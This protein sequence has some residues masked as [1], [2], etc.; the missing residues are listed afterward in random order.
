MVEK[1]E[2]TFLGETYLIDSDVA[3]EIFQCVAQLPIVD[4]HTHISVEEMTLNKG[5]NN[6][7]DVFGATDH[8]VWELMRR[9]GVPEEKITGSASPKEKWISFAEIVPSIC[10]NP[11]YEWLHLELR[12][13]FGIYELVSAKTAEFIWDKLEELLKSP[14]MRPQ[15]MLRKM[16]VEVLC[17][18]ESPVCNLRWYEKIRDTVAFS[19]IIP[20]WRPDEFMEIGTAE[21]KTAIRKLE[22]YVDKELINCSELVLALERT[23][24]D[25]R[26]MG[27]ISSD[28]GI[29]DAYGKPPAMNNANKIFQKANAGKKLSS[30]EK[31]AFK[32]FLLHCFAEMDVAAGW[33]MQ[34]HLGAV[35]NYRMA[36]ARS[37]GKDAGGD[38][39]NHM[40]EIVK[41][42]YNFLNNFDEKLLII[43]Y[44][45]HPCHVYTIATLART[46]PNVIIGAPWWFMNNPYNIKEQLLQISNV[47]ILTNYIG[48]VSDARRLLSISSRFEIFRRILS[49]VL[50]DMVCKG[51]LPIE[52]AKYVCQQV[53]YYNSKKLFSK[54]TEKVNN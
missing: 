32:A 22:E 41:S 43:I 53:A 48:M 49:N 36:L 7:W 40:I 14:D 15:E 13:H 29:E 24:S 38:V 21:W 1:K 16:Q 45:L 12:R 6:A 39:A 4:L 9:C 2:T 18:T 52:M 33:V 30:E 35:R 46:F 20:T 27:A 23:H 31:R 10:G 47:D 51:R 3:M 44:V 42:L 28:H 50:G 26:A 11:F 25:F 8:Y 5:W 19:R 17:T 37:I 34:L 54:L